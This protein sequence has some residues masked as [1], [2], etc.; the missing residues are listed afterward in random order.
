MESL[1][2]VSAAMEH[3]LTA[4][5]DEAAAAVGFVRRRRVLTGAL[6]AQ[7][8]VLGWL[9]RPAATLHQLT[10]AV[11]ARG[12]AISPQGLAQRF[13]P[14]AAALL[15]RVLAAAVAAP[16][17]ADPA[18]VP[19]L[20]R[21]GGGVW[22]LD[23][24]TV[25]L[26]DA[27]AAVWR[28]CGGRTGKGTQ[29]A[30]K[31]QVRF[32]LAGGEL[33]GPLLL[34]GRTQDK[35]GGLH[36]APLPPGALLLADL[37][38]WSLER[39][40]A[41]GAAGAF[42]LSRLDPHTRVLAPSGDR[43]DLP[44]WLA[45][46]KAPTVE[47]EV[48]V[49][50]AARLPARL[51]AAKV[52]KAVADARRRKLRAAAKREGKAAP[53]A[54]LALTGWTVYVTNVPADRLTLAEA[55]VLGRARWQVELLFKLWKSGGGLDESRS[56]DPW[57]VLCEL[58]AKLTALVVQHWILLVGCWDRPDRSLTRAAQTVREHAVCL[59][60]ALGRPDCLAE[61]LAALA[62]CL[63]AGC[64]VAARKTRPSAYQLWL[65]PG[66]GGLT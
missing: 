50:A 48:L 63:R 58:Y 46:A 14:E 6:F 3:V 2:Q 62:A 24:T 15:E 21:F 18:A 11:A 28:G 23:C 60:R 59:L 10:Q 29:A 12:G 45:R 8:L 66:L 39:L 40:R 41:L 49:G 17:R 57:R 13:G 27:L 37:G 64:R 54:T 20:A 4:V 30:L 36:H 1:P 52:P 44:R 65:D 53:A 35:A 9:A 25:R 5:A 43:L 47:A 7:A 31:L 34:A 61:E 32:D 38:Y 51:L 42:W 19:L 33:E 55:F 22:L 16:V 26:P 56:A